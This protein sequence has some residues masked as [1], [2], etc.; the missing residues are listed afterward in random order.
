MAKR[1]IILEHVQ[2]PETHQPEVVE[3]EPQAPVGKQ[4]TWCSRTLG[5]PGCSECCLKAAEPQD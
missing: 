1:V 5:K 2:C 3:Y 4:V